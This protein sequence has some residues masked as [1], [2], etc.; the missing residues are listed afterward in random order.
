MPVPTTIADLDPVAANNYPTGSESVG[1]NLDDYLRAHAAILK[2]VSNSI[3][4]A[5]SA[6]IPAGVILMWSGSVAS[7]PAGWKLCDGTLGTPDLRSRFVVGAGSSY[8]P[9]ATG[10]ADTVTLNANQMPV[11]AHG[12]SDPGHAHS[13]YDPGHNHGVND[14]GHTHSVPTSPGTGGSPGPARGSGIDSSVGTGGSVTGIWLNASGTG[15][16]IYGAATNISIQNAGSGQA[17][18]NR[19]PYYALAFIQKT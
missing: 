3:A 9:G 8:A 6:A 5:I 4:P 12:V 17:H 1:P 2:Q 14:P 19:P 13:V 7:I 16:G 18:E 15:I 11:H 10:G